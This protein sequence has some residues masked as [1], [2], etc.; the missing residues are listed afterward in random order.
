MNFF[1]CWASQISHIFELSIFDYVHCL[2]WGIDWS[3][4]FRYPLTIDRMIMGQTYIEQKREATGRRKYADITYAGTLTSIG[5]RQSPV[6]LGDPE[7]VA[8]VL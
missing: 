7:R 8:S 4:A 5:K 3:K 6:G 1:D 2:D